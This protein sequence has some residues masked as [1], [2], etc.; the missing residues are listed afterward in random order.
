MSDPI[1]EAAIRA[2]ARDLGAECIIE[3]VRL[4]TG[5]PVD[6]DL[7]AAIGGLTGKRYDP[8]T[9]TWSRPKAGP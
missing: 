4:V 9:G 3:S 2:A 8:E 6:P 7:I 5:S 1:D